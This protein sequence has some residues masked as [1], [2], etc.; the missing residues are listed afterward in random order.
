M[1]ST[2][3]ITGVVAS[4]KWGYLPAAAL[5]GWTLTKTADG[6]SLVAAVVSA[7]AF[8]L[9]QQP[10]VFVAPHQDGAWRWPIVALQITGASLSATLG[11]KECTDAVPVRPT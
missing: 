1:A 2:V 8:R 6:W 11:P 7:D 3:T 9:S 4:L 10:L 5:T